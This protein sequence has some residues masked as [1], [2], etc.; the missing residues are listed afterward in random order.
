[1]PHRTIPP[2]NRGFAKA[3][4][5]EMTKAELRLWL[6][7]RKPGV[8]GLRFRRQTPV[9]P[10]IVDFFCPQRK[11]IVEVDGSQHAFPDG[12]RRDAERDAWLRQRGYIVVRVGNLDVMSNIEGVCDTIL[13]AANG[14]LTHSPSER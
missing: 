6:R 1:M 13:G 9:G 7:L 5:Q 4:R 8:G 10:F 12:V 2:A 14:E 11:L 3:M